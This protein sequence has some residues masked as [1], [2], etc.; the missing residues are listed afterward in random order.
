MKRSLKRVWLFIV[1]FTLMATLLSGIGLAERKVQLSLWSVSSP[2]DS[3]GIWLNN[4]IKEYEAKN[5][6]VQVNYVYSTDETYK[7]K[8]QVAMFGG[9]GPDIFAT[10]GFEHEAQF[11][12]QG[13]LYDLTKTLGKDKWGLS[14]GTFSGHTFQG[15]IYAIPQDLQIGL[16]W[17]NKK[18]FDANGW[19]APKTW[20]EFLT[21][22][23]KIKAKNIIPVA[24][25][26]RDTWTILQPF[27]YMVDRIGGSKLYTDAKLGKTSFTNSVF[28][29][30]FGMIEELSKKAYLPKD[31]LSLGYDDAVQLMVQ[32]KAAMEFMGDWLYN[33]L[34]DNL[35]RNLDEWDFF[36][37]PLVDGGKGDPKA[38]IGA[39]D[40]FAVN[41]ACKNPDEA[42]KFMKFL[43][44]EKN[45]VKYFKASGTFVTLAKPY[46][47][48]NDLVVKKKEAAIIANVSSMTGWWDQDLP[49]PM[50]Q[51]LLTSLQEVV[52]G[53]KAPK[54]AAQAIEDARK[55]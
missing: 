5:P 31:V 32:D 1:A 37:F 29:K 23:E 22:C 17:Y 11:V 28:V 38:V 24:M 9:A 55:K 52:G 4:V 25:G 47:R 13:L 21:L 44:S 15:K 53:A 54:Y 16:V 2:E 12:R 39:S 27:M 18:M 30:A 14:K 42:I 7:T 3:R 49:R 8:L 50:T 35:K 10:W 41:K 51:A 46:L 33:N 40:G 43:Y 34:T 20:T 26:G 6:N 19:S 48:K 45:L 36:T